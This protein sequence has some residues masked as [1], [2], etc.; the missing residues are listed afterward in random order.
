MVEM[1]SNSGDRD[2]RA[3]EHEL[4]TRFKVIKFPKSLRS[5]SEDLHESRDR[6]ERGAPAI[7]SSNGGAVNEVTR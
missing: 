5:R 1:S 2:R 3:D 4:Q 7:E 6:R